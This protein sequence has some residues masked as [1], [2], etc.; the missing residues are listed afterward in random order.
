MVHIKDPISDPGTPEEEAMRYRALPL[1]SQYHRYLNLKQLI[2]TKYHYY[3]RPEGED[4]MGKII[5]LNRLAWGPAMFYGIF[6]SIMI[7][8]EKTF[9]TRTARIIHF[10]WPAAACAT[11]FATG[12]YAANRIRGK[13][14]L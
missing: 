9:Y 6:D 11:A 8:Q 3:N 13:D 2:A 10:M 12:A 14:D 5:H 7:K 4:L 1:M